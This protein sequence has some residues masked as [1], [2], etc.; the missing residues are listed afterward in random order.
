MR[1][2]LVDFL[3]ALRDPQT[4][5]QTA[6]GHLVVLATSLG[7]DHVNLALVSKEGDG[8]PISHMWSTMPAPWLDE[9][10][11]CGMSAHDYAVRGLL[12]SPDWP[13]F[14]RIEW[15][16][17]SV[18]R[19]GDP[20]AATRQVL[21]GSADAGLGQALAFG[22]DLSA[23]SLD[24]STS[25]GCAIGVET[26]RERSSFFEHVRDIEDLM[27]TACFAMLPLLSRYQQRHRL[28]VHTLSRRE[29]EVLQ[30]LAAGLRP[31]AI[32]D[33]LRIARVT[34]DLHISRARRKLH[35]RTPAEAIATA[36]RS[37][38]VG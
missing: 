4:D 38:L 26:R 17:R 18:L 21:A 8:L 1:P 2:E 30:F 9:Y 28:G 5:V 13:G 6:Y 11:E 3:T 14:S 34:V 33:R 23:S 36:M 35:A 7:I 32:A 25:V 19:T 12:D 27:V 24:A 22:I 16:A 10:F 37:G 31:D 20:S 29:R 15:D